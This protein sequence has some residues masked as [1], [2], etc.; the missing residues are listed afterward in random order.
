MHQSEAK[1]LLLW[2]DGCA[3]QNKNHTMVGFLASLVRDGDF[4]SVNHKFLVKG[5]LT[6]LMT[7]TQIEKQKPT[8]RVEFTYCKTGSHISSRQKK[9]HPF[10]V[11]SLTWEASKDY[12][13][14]ASRNFRMLTKTTCKQNV[15]FKQMSW[16]SCGESLEEGVTKHHPDELWI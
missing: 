10:T 2:S 12:K 9:K 13:T 1:Y 15:N 11:T 4:L 8:A 6:F 14:Y 3:G 5:H 7:M 16:F